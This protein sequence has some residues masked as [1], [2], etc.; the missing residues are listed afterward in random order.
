MAQVA[1]RMSTPKTVFLKNA[2]PS[3]DNATPL[4]TSSFP[5]FLA[6]VF[7]HFSK[8]DS[9]SQF[10]ISRRL[11]SKTLLLFLS[12]Q[13]LF[14]AVKFGHSYRRTWYLYAVLMYVCAPSCAWV[15]LTQ[16]ATWPAIQPYITVFNSSTAASCL[17]LST[18]QLQRLFS[19]KHL[20]VILVPGP[21]VC[22]FL[23]F[24]CLSYTRYYQNLS[25]SCC[26]YRRWRRY[27]LPFQNCD[28][29]SANERPS[30]GSGSSC[31]NTSSGSNDNYL[32]FTCFQLSLSVFERRCPEHHWFVVLSVVFKGAPPAPLKEHSQCS[33]RQ[34]RLLLVFF[35][36]VR[37]LG[38][39]LFL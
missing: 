12:R 21:T 26:R 5:V 32:G 31:R 18:I 4:S 7:H 33:C 9:N 25:S 11:L 3:S 30:F 37:F 16:T 29:S 39:I 10:I 1:C 2:R 36:R 20:C 14:L 34:R 35:S 22:R 6:A 27:N 38:F 8:I 13:L 23:V 28:L 19:T 15:L 24:F 17:C